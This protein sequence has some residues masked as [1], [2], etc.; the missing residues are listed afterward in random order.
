[1]VTTLFEYVPSLLYSRSVLNSIWKRRSLPLTLPW[2]SLGFLRLSKENSQMNMLHMNRR[3]TT[4]GLTTYS[5]HISQGSTT[6]SSEATSFSFFHPSHQYQ[7]QYH[8]IYLH[9]V[10][11]S[12]AC[13]PCISQGGWRVFNGLRGLRMISKKKQ[14]ITQSWRP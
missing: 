4:H 8:L 14:V 7:L 11:I 6:G 5:V 1:M 12:S 13:M 9:A 2:L 10:T 3:S